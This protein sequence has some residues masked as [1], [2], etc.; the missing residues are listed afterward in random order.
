MSWR[1][2][3]LDTLRGIILIVGGVDA[4]KSTLVRYLWAELAHR[5]PETLAVLDADIGQATLGPP[6]TQT[7]RMARPG[8][9]GRFPPRGRVARWFV[10]A[11]SPRGHL[12]P[13]VVGMA[14]LLQRAR[15]W[16]V[17]T[18]L[19]DTTGLI[20]PNAGGVVL[21]WA[22]ID[23]LHPDVVVTLQR[24]RE[25]EPLIAPWR[26]SHRFR[27]IELPVSP[28]ASPRP[29]EE[30]LA[31]RQARFRHYFRRAE[32]WEIPTGQMTVLG[33]MPL[34]PGRL[35]GFLDRRGYLLALGILKEWQDGLW[36]VFTPLR[37]LSAV[38]A[39]RL[40]DVVLDESWRDHR[41]PLPHRGAPSPAAGA[42]PSS[43]ST[44]PKDGLGENVGR[45]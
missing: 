8:E 9:A 44:S 33:R 11:V 39:I 43:S 13:A 15:A 2:L 34:L 21:K 23:L 19:V 16:G 38:D 40:G 37:R 30:R 28:D 1:R 24:E 45:V 3:S 31:W 41:L 6:T 7:V 5:T 4:G 20:H 32:E 29:R 42:G 12:L 14:R 25:L 27:L 35:L 22:Q 10:G 17:S 18:L 36:N 26:Q